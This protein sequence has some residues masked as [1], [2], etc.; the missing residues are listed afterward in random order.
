[1]TII[2]QKVVQRHGLLVGGNPTSYKIADTYAELAATSDNITGDIAYIHDQ[3]RSYLYVAP[4]GWYRCAL[5]V[6]IPA[7]TPAFNGGTITGDIAINKNVG[8]Y[9]VGSIFQASGTRTSRFQGLPNNCAI[10]SQGIQYVESVGWVRDH[11][12]IPGSALLLGGNEQG[13]PG[14]TYYNDV[15]G[16]ITNRFSIDVNGSILSNG[17]INIGANQLTCGPIVCSTINTQTNVISAGAISASTVTCGPLNN[18]TQEASNYIRTQ[19]AFYEYGRVNPQG[20]PIGFYASNR[21]SSPN[22]T[23]T[24]EPGDTLTFHYT[25]IG[26]QCTMFFVL[27]NTALSAATARVNFSV[28]FASSGH[29]YNSCL[30]GNPSTVPAYVFIDPGSGTA[31]VSRVDGAN[32]SG[33]LHIYG[34][35][36]YT[37]N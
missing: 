15:G 5:V 22:G 26:K 35:L 8:T 14:V 16:T 33:T 28:P 19:N 32:M 34:H 29:F 11:G 18:S 12:G 6:D 7:A 20:T 2:D 25:I 37:F 27:V 17:Q 24:V 36:V 9:A 1:M 13:T 30:I 21:F 23:W 10:F 31:G 4:G 3:G